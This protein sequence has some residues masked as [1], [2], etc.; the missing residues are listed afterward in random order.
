MRRCRRVTVPAIWRLFTP[1][2]N[3][4]KL[5]NI[6]TQHKICLCIDMTLNIT[7]RQLQVLDAVVR[8]GSHTR[9][10]DEVGL[11]QPAVS[12]Q[13]KQLERQLQV[14][15][16]EH[17]GKALQLT[18][19]GAEVLRRARA[20]LDELDELETALDDMKGLKRGKLRISTVTT[21]NY[22]AP[23]L[24]RTFC[25]RH[26][27]ITVTVGVANRQELLNELADNALDLVIM[28]RPPEDAGLLAEPFLENPLVIVAPADHPLARA[29]AIAPDRLE[30][31][32]FLMRERGSGTRGAMERWLDEHGLTIRS[33]IEVSGAEALKQ[34]VQAGLGL[35][36]MS[37]DAV[38]MELN[39]GR[40]VELNVQD[41]PI[42]RHWYVVHREGKH[43]SGP[44]K[45]FKAFVLS[46]ASELLKRELPEPPKAPSAAV[47]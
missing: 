44:A 4:R 34:G 41:F 35:A 26:P 28:G 23:T 32:V 2:H 18:E 33:S 8:N 45:A 1:R 30:A 6:D 20:V 16:L 22:F 11:T 17:Q 43:L 36:L 47:S 40:L 19:A 27:G 25:A 12:M 24:L 14:Q 31:E 38:Q 13:I 39:L 46:E 9:A 10:A 15:L 7:I 42:P 21:V 29:A 37:R 3:I 5:I